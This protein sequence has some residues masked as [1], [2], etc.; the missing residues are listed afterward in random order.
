MA[1]GEVRNPAPG[2]GPEAVVQATLFVRGQD[3][4]DA[5]RDIVRFG[6]VQRPMLG[7]VMDRDTN[8]IDQLLPNGPAER[9]G[10]IEGDRVVGVAGTPTGSLADVT[11]HLL[12]RSIGELLVIDVERDGQSLERVVRLAA[13]DL[14]DLPTVEPFPGAELQLSADVDEHGGR[15]VT[16]LDVKVGSS[17][18]AAGVRTGD[19]LISVDGRDAMRF[20]AR[21]RIRPSDAFPHVMTIERGDERH[22]ILLGR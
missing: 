4:H 3:V 5:V 11:R 12:R 6:K 22:V 14:P 10:L 1:V 21:H 9:A 19:R 18:H 16:F 13:M 20:L 15:T 2:S 17:L 8:R 7:V